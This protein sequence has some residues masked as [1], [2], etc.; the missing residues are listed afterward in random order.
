MHS[1]LYLLEFS[2]VI[3]LIFLLLCLSNYVLET[4]AHIIDIVQRLP[5][6]HSQL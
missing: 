2:L 4:G 3:E 1:I 5:E 6:L